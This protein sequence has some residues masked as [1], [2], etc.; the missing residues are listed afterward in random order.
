MAEEGDGLLYIYRLG[1]YPLL[2][3]PKVSVDGCKVFSP[4]EKAYTWMHLSAGQHRVCIDW[5]WDAGWPDLEFDIPIIENREHYIKISGSSEHYPFLWR[6]GSE[7]LFV[8]KEIAEKELLAHCKYI[9]PITQNP[10][11]TNQQLKS[12]R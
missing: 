5:A 1:A 8:N 9:A 7:A 4:P 10:N 3:A 2:K 6:R 12:T 11:S